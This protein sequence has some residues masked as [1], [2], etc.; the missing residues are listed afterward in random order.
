MNYLREINAF[1]DRLESSPLSSSAIV[2]WH[3]LMHINN[4]SGW[5]EEFSAPNL[6]LS[7]K[8]GLSERTIR[9][10]RNELKTKRYIGFRTR[11]GN[12]A[13]IYSMMSLSANNAGNLSGNASDNLSGSVSGTSSAYLNKTKEKEEEGDKARGE[14]PHQFFQENF[15]MASPYI[16]EC[17]S[18]WCEDM[19]D[20]IVVA[21]MKLAL[22]NGARAFSYIEKILKDWSSENLKDLEAIRMYER[23]RR[24]AKSNNTI[25]FP[26]RSSHKTLEVIEELRKEGAHDS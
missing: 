20:E 6:T 4:K 3:A 15:G 5:K 8:T 23:Q 19:G 12:R 16:L 17:I 22:S 13:A 14:N 1:Y 24:K 9:N 11:T 21:A 10:A 25:P 7:L 2:L 18:Y 26:K